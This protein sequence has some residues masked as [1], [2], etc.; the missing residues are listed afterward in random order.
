MALCNKIW[1]YL[2]NY[3]QPVCKKEAQAVDDRLG[4]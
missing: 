3:L 1:G 2:M 4:C